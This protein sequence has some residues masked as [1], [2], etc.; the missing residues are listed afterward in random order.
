APRAGAVARVVLGPARAAR[1]PVEPVVEAAE[2][3]QEAERDDDRPDDDQ[4]L[5]EPV[6]VE[7]EAG[8]GAVDDPGRDREGERRRPEDAQ[9][10]RRGQS[11]ESA[12]P[13][14]WD[15]R[16]VELRDAADVVLGL[17]RHSTIPSSPA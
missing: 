1:G 5:Q 9:P 17:G 3:D 16:R 6:R 4:R 10:A 12:G 2:G 11:A 14:G 7:A 13:A 15:V 8:P